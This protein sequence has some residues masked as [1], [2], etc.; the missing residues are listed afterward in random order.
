MVILITLS[1]IYAVISL[2]SNSVM[3]KNKDV[4]IVEHIFGF[5]AQKFISLE[6]GGLKVRIFC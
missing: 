5:S 4:D 3:H 1:Y 6:N 2:F